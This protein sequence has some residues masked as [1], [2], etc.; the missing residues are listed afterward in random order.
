MVFVSALH[1]GK[2]SESPVLLFSADLGLGAKWRNPATG[3]SQKDDVHAALSV[4]RKDDEKGEEDRLLY[5]AMTR[6]EDRLILSYA[7]KKQSSPWQKRAEAGIGAETGADRA[8]EIHASG[9]FE[10][11][12][13]GDAGAFAGGCGGYG[14]T[15]FIGGGDGRGAVRGLPS[16]ILSGA[17][18]GGDAGANG[19]G[20][21][22]DRAGIGGSQS[23]GGAAHRI[24]GGFGAEAAVR[25]QRTGAAYGGS[26]ASGTRVR[27]SAG[28]GRCGSTRADRPVV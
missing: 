28:G 6:A 10:P 14:A 16:Q 13:Y 27:F 8:T 5:V 18:F 4:R 7:R 25:E 12:G 21:R 9:A 20:D 24:A 11:L 22:R 15:R 1:A 2:N 17:V 3:E 19:S 23:A 26:E